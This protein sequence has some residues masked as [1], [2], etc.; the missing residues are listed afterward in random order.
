[1]LVFLL[2]PKLALGQSFAIN[3]PLDPSQYSPLDGAERLQ[4]WINE[5]GA[6]AA[7][8]LHALVMSGITQSMNDPSQW[9]RT[10]RGF[11]R[12][13][14]GEYGGSLIANS[15]HEGLAAAEGTDPRYF[16]CSCTGLF[17]RS[18]HA[19]EMTFLTYDRNGRKTLD[20]PQLT[21]QYAGAMISKTWWPQHYN[22]LVQGV[23]GGHVEM[24]LLASVH[25][26]QEFSPELKRLFHVR[27]KT[28]LAWTTQ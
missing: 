17:R 9:G 27:N 1:L 25:I 2:A 22:P 12:R 8:H 26:V 7:F 15:V 23:Q 28:V 5:D 16:P 24:G 3:E 20:L 21:S 14:G 4:R 13:V 11:A 19:L 6:S 10:P 18:G